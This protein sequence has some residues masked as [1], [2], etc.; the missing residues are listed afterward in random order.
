M[1]KATEPVRVIHRL[2]DGS[3]RESMAGLMIPGSAIEFYA[4]LGRIIARHAQQAEAEK[5]FNPRSHARS[6]RREV[7]RC[8]W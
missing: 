1:A 8:R 2:A 4:V 7:Q 3:T 5:H 6:D